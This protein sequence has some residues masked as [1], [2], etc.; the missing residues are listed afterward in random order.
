MDAAAIELSEATLISE[1]SDEAREAAAKRRGPHVPLHSAS[2]P[3]I[4]H[5][6]RNR[7]NAP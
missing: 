3:S 6:A 1:V 5:P 4:Y 2:R 7:R